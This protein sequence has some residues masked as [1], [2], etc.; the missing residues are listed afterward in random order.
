MPLPSL[1][2]WIHK[3]SVSWKLS[4]WG[5]PIKL[6][7]ITMEYSEIIFPLNF[8]PEIL[9]QPLQSTW[10]SASQKL[11]CVIKSPRLSAFKSANASFS[12]KEAF[13]SWYWNQKGSQN[14]I[15]NLSAI[16][17]CF[18]CS[19]Q[20]WFAYNFMTLILENS[21]SFF[22][23]LF[24]FFFPFL[25]RINFEVSLLIVSSI[26]WFIQYCW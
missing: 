7:C 22:S 14:L 9:K 17:L 10:Q 3:S 8:M 4:P 5:C 11:E 18:K 2:A 1:S 21:L 13:R 23:F 19:H 20:K 6:I 16:D 12:A 15:K 25:F 26:F 24:F